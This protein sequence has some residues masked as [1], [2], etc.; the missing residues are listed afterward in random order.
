MSDLKDA[1][2][3]DLFA[4]KF[5]NVR[6]KVLATTVPQF[7][8]NQP[9]KIPSVSLFIWDEMVHRNLVSEP[10]KIAPVINNGYHGIYEFVRDE[11]G[12]E[13]IRDVLSTKYFNEINSAEPFAD[14]SLALCYPNDI[15]IIDV[16]FSDNRHPL[17]Q[18]DPSRGLRKY[19]G[20]HIF[21][22]FLERLK[23]V[24]RVKQ[25]DRL[26]LMVAEPPLYQVFRK[27]GFAVSKTQMSQRAFKMARHGF[28]MVLP[29]S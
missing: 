7:L 21:G 22:T 17:P 28:A 15:H 10:F 5:T 13:P 1:I 11:L 27:H 26:S 4:T 12:E 16:E 9:A 6:E 18:D 25:A 3:T 24:A 2:P 23:A 20:L 19:K 29:V 14:V 8:E